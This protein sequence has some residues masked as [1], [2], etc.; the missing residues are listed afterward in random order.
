M[1]RLLGATLCAV[2]LLLGFGDG[3]AFGKTFK[4]GTVF[5]ETQPDSRGA[6]LFAKLVSEAT[7]GDIQIQVF[8]NSQ[9]GGGCPYLHFGGHRR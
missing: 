6:V 3:I 2:G 7:N 9:L 1:K 4:L 8:P 5:P